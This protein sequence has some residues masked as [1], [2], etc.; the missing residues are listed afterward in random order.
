MMPGLYG[1]IPGIANPTGW[2]LLTI[3]IVLVP[4][5]LP[6]VRKTG[7][8]EACMSTLAFIITILNLFYLLF[9]FLLQLFYWT[10]LLHFPFWVLLILHGPHFWYWFIGPGTLFLLL[11]KLLRLRKRQSGKGKTFINQA[12]LLPSR[13]TH[14]V[15]R[16]P[17][18]FNFHPGDYVY[19]NIPAIASSEW[20]PFTIS[21]P[22]ELPGTAILSPPSKGINARTVI[23]VFTDLLWLHIRGV[24]GWT[25]KLYEYF[26]RE[27]M[28]LSNNAL[29][30]I[31]P[32]CT[33]ITSHQP[34]IQFSRQSSR[35]SRQSSRTE[36]IINGT[37]GEQQTSS[38]TPKRTNRVYR[39]NEMH[40]NNL[41]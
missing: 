28:E 21:S 41:N 26:K 37:N 12:I 24:G 38:G 13:V 35:F 7:Y 17:S 3:L 39:Y 22:P 2:G 5:S 6:F 14:L 19:V 11:E 40:R 1:L 34:S 23:M 27:Q 32:I 33:N 9:T 29:N 20:H 30:H 31:Q 10:H 18:N 4:C 15:C 36:T 16:K 25:N 8:F